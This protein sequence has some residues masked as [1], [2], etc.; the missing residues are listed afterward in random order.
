MNPLSRPPDVSPAGWCIISGESKILATPPSA[1][2]SYSTDGRP[3]AKTIERPSGL[4][5]P[6][7]QPRGRAASVAGGPPLTETFFSSPRVANPMK[8]LLG[9]QKGSGSFATFDNL[10]LLLVEI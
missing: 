6:P 8:S 9:D 5:V 4:Q 1:E 10:R 2:I 3:E 7:P